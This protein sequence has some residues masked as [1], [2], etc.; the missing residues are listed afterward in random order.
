MEEIK[1]QFKEIEFMKW[2]V[3]GLFFSIPSLAIIATVLVTVGGYLFADK[4]ETDEGFYEVN[5]NISE[6]TKQVELQTQANVSKDAQIRRDIS[7]Q[8]QKFLD[9]KAER[10]RELEEEARQNRTIASLV[11]DLA[12]VAEWVKD[13]KRKEGRD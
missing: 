12:V 11:T 13:Q 7:R 8:E 10:L 4:T 1:A 2:L 5:S 9:M 3:R 6:L